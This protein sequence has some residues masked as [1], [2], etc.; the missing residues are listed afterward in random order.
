M[1][2]RAENTRLLL[3]AGSTK[4]ALIFFNVQKMRDGFVIDRHS[5]FGLSDYAWAC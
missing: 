2:N 1:L 5:S 4:L 3:I